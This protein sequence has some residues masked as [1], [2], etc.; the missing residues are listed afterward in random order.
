M[1]TDACSRVERMQITRI[2]QSDSNMHT[3]S[4]AISFCRDWKLQTAEEAAAGVGTR[5]QPTDVPSPRQQRDS[6][7]AAQVACLRRRVPLAGDGGSAHRP[8]QRIF[9]SWQSETVAVP[10]SSS[11]AGRKPGECKTSDLRL[12][13]PMT[14][15]SCI[16]KSLP[17]KFF[18]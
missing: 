6:V 16:Y 15:H 11:P 14:A 17:Q 12:L 1:T 10:E 18:F 7:Q 3:M 2:P 9:H 5:K 8:Q 4:C 13:M